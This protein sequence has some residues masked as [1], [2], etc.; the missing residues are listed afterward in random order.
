MQG[1]FMRKGQV[2]GRVEDLG[3]LRVTAVVDQATNASVMGAA[4]GE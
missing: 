2:I 1:R 3:S 4:P